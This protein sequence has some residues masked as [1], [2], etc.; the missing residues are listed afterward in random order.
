MKAA[1]INIQGY[2]VRLSKTLVMRVILVYQS[3]RE[4]G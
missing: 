2:S 1:I 3:K 4:I